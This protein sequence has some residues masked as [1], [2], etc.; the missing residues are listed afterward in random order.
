MNKRVA[1]ALRR[2]SLRF[3]ERNHPHLSLAHL[4]REYQRRPRDQRAAYRRN[5]EELAK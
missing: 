1:K 5:A 3:A 4:K 2:L